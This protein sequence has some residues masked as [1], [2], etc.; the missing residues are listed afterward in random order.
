MKPN[1]SHLDF[2]ASGLTLALFLAMPVWAQDGQPQEGKDWGNYHVN[3]SIEI[4]WR[5]TDFTGNQD[6]Y[7]TFVNLGQGARLYNQTL[8]MRSLNHQGMLFDTFYL[9]SFGYGGDPSDFSTLRL[10]KNKW[11]NFNA[12]FRRDRN[13]WNY[14]LLAN[15]L[16][17]TNSNPTVIVRFSPHA[18]ALTRRMSDYNL[19]LLPQSRVR[20]RLGYNRNINE[21]PSLTTLHVGTEALLF[22]DWKTTTNAYQAGVDFK[23]LPRTNFS[24][25]QFLNYYKGD[26]AWLDNQFAFQLSTGQ[27]VDLGVSWD[28]KNNNPCGKPIINSSTTPPTANPKCSAYTA[29]TRTEPVR[30]SYPTEQFSFQS[31]YFNNVDMSGRFV[32]SSADAR[33]ANFGELFQGFESRTLARQLTTAGSAKVKRTTVSADYAVTWSVNSKFRVV[34]EFRFNYFRIPGQNNLSTTA[35]FATSLAI[36][37]VVFNPTTCPPPF[38]AAAC[39]P[40]NGSSEADAATARASLFLG[41]DMK[42]N[43]I[44]FEYDFTKRFGGRLGY[45]Y[46]HR[47][48]DQRLVT[49]STS[50][51]DPVLAP[52]GPCQGQPLN[53]DGSCTVDSSSES[54]GSTT[55]NEHSL[56]AGIWARPIDALRLSYDQEL[57][58]ADNT[59]TR[60]SPRQFQHYK[61]RANYK[62]T[63]W[64]SFAG[65]FNVL[66]ARNNV[67][68]V[69]HLEHTRNYGFGATFARSE[70]WSLD[71]GYNY[72]GI[73]S[74]TNICF[75]F[76]FG[77]PPPGFPPCP[78]LGSP[79]PLQGI[80]IYNNKLNYGYGELV[81]KPVKRVTL[82]L[83]YS[84]DSVTGNTLILNPNSPP[85]PL[86]FNYHRPNAGV[87]IDLARN[88]TWKTSWGFYDY[89]EKG[90]STDP[91]GPRSFRGNLVNLSVVYAF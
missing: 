6:V 17:P 38:T 14:D 41:Q 58:S 28:T 18:M 75:I 77:P 65:T 44:Q 2:A 47:I 91:I 70:K 26:T 46:R 33:V 64:M 62:P 71:L 66:E 19:T 43:T 15:P 34:D 4:G 45:R 37:P 16:N 60:I 88:W 53:P 68:Q 12:N 25:D 42:L 9:A 74:Q 39:P 13:L 31:S 3:Q 79:V 22:Q 69:N 20:F 10:S 61:F 57:M 56:L 50:T 89:N 90:V 78:I 49:I 63:S 32:Y 54:S 52:T 72:T 86:N 73:F 84:I 29:Y 59:F 83:G 23:V 85:G 48:I 67:S 5:G 36:A 21:G 7:D 76:G 1:R 80:S 11:Y 82:N 40:H 51:F 8:Q 55:I 27:L 87:A 24:F 35:L 81:V 30:T